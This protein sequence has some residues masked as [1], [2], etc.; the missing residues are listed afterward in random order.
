MMDDILLYVVFLASDSDPHSDRHFV[1]SAQE[2]FRSRQEGSGWLGGDGWASDVDE[3]EAGGVAYF[4]GEI[5]RDA[6]FLGPCAECS[7]H[8]GHLRWERE[9]EIYL[10]DLCQRIGV[11]FVVRNHGGDNFSNARDKHDL[12]LLPDPD[13]QELIVLG[14]MMDAVRFVHKF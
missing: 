4:A 3:L 14:G 10:I 12:T 5:T 9:T 1:P 6:L 13:V 7:G 2:L 8:T 11:R